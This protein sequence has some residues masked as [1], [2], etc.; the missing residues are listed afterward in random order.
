MLE[1][2]DRAPLLARRF[3][4]EWFAKWGIEDDDVGRLVVCELVTNSYLH[5]K[6]QIVVR[7]FR[8]E[9]DGRPVVEVWDAGEER[10]EIQPEDTGALTG[11]GLVLLAELVHDWGVRLLNEGGKVVWATLR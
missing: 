1:P 2:T 11:R 4:A 7:V 5:G 9:R 6:G 3:L 8:D 10:P